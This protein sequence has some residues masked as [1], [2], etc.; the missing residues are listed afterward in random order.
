MTARALVAA[1]VAAALLLAWLFWPKA[2]DGAAPIE[3]RAR[4]DLVGACNQAAAAS[5]ATTRFAP[6]DVSSRLEATE[7]E[8]GVVALVSVFEARR[9]GLLC[10]WSGLDPATIVSAD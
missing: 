10:K 7:A 1:G 8:G 3:R 9:D 2:E 5:G 4:L 6:E